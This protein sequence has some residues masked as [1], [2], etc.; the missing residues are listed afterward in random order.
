MSR[1]L[2]VV[3]GIV[4]AA[5]SVIWGSI[6][7]GSYVFLKAMG[8]IEDFAFPW[9]QLIVA[10]PEIIDNGWY[11]MSTLRVWNSAV[12]GVLVTLMPPL[13]ISA[14]ILRRLFDRF[15]RPSLYGKMDFA[16]PDKMRRSGF[17]LTK[18]R[19]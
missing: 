18:D 17:R 7:L 14:L 10:I 3:I 6:A 16:S 8:Y 11:G 5:A 9:N 12:I 15:R 13:L 19:F 4:I 1:Q 2:P